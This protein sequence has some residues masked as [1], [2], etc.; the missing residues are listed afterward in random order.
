VVAYANAVGAAIPPMILFKGKGMKR[1]FADDLAPGS[2]SEI[3]KCPF[4][5]PYCEPLFCIFEFCK[6][7]KFE[8]SSKNICQPLLC[9]ISIKE[10]KVSI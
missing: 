2:V 9:F 7:L 10:I 4:M 8:I 1:E 5:R 3:D 6:L